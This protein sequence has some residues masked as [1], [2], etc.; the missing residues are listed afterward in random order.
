VLSQ[1]LKAL[2]FFVG[3]FQKKVFELDWFIGLE[4][5]IRSFRRI[6]MR[7]FLNKI[8]LTTLLSCTA[9]ILCKGDAKANWEPGYSVD[10]P[11][12]NYYMQPSYAVGG[13]Y[14]PP[15]DYYGDGYG[16]QYGNP[17]SNPY[18]NP[19][20]YPY[21]G[22]HYGHYGNYGSQ[23][24]LCPCQWSVTAKGGAAFGFYAGRQ[25]NEVRNFVG[26]AEFPIGTGALIETLIV[27]ADDIKTPKFNDQ[28]DHGWTVGGE[29]AYALSRNTEI[30]LD[31]NYLKAKG[32]SD[33]Y[34]VAFP[35]ILAT[36]PDFAEIVVAPAETI[37]IRERYSDLDSYDGYLGFRYYFPRCGGASFFVGTKIGFR[38]WD[39][40]SAR[41]TSTTEFINSLG[42]PEIIE[43][44]LGRNPYYKEHTVVSGGIQIGLN[45][46]F[47]KCFSLVL[48]AEAIA[49]GPFKF[50]K[51]RFV[52]NLA[53]TL[54]P[55]EGSEIETLTI[56]DVPV[57]KM[58]T[59][60]V[61]PI[62]VGLRYTF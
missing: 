38:H 34:S 40:V 59:I 3:K 5:I 57:R 6:F 33:S 53:Q 58:G 25:E 26:V 45:Y 20:A 31:G 17:Y 43:Q 16:Y 36:S 42:A 19:Y 18:S 47:S 35:E 30:F 60:F 61:F 14:N 62:T 48:T 11:Y 7:F 28:F 2:F 50:G 23:G 44:D 46:C 8:S 24:P 22:Y 27:Q 41:I 49:S 1:K 56:L 13:G 4:T 39:E 32:K 10:Q 51:N 55:A 29:I 37:T 52:N 54:T 15:V 9:I 21:A 12:E